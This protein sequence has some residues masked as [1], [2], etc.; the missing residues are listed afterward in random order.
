MSAHA[1]SK[2]RQTACLG[3]S[4]SERQVGRSS[5]LLFG[6]GDLDAFALAASVTRSSWSQEL[7][8]ECLRRDDQG[9]AG[10]GKAICIDVT[11]VE[12]N[13]ERKRSADLLLVVRERS[14]DGFSMALDFD[15]KPGLGVSDYDEIHLA[16]LFVAQVP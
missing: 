2:G 15:E 7:G 10:P 9:S 6:T 13:L 1:A 8:E 3:P 4:Q 14:T 11:R 16:S 12:N 5:S